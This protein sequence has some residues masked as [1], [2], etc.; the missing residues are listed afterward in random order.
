MNNTIRKLVQGVHCMLHGVLVLIIKM[1][2]GRV[3]TT[4]ARI[5]KRLKDRTKTN[6]I[7]ICSGKVILG[8]GLASPNITSTDQ[9]NMILVLVLSNKCILLCCNIHQLKSFL[10]S[11]RSQINI[12]FKIL[13]H[14]EIEIV[15]S[16]MEHIAVEQHRCQSF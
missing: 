9:M 3:R 12:F 1:C 11:S 15:L 6:I 2:D 14:E 7:F 8:L 5:I 10:K 16:I 4:W 13:S